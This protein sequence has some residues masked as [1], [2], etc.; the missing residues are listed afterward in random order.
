[1]QAFGQSREARELYEESL[2]LEP[3]N[4]DVLAGLGALLY[5]TDAP[6]AVELFQKAIRSRATLIRPYIL[7][8]HY[9]LVRQEFAR[10]FGYARQAMDFARVDRARAAL[11]EIMAI[12]ASELGASAD[13]VLPMISEA[14]RLAPNAA[15]IG[16]NLK[17]F[18]KSRDS[19]AAKAEW[20]YQEERADYAMKE[21]IERASLEVTA[22][23]G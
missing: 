1:M 16:E 14:A 11:L 10:A 8:A 19:H 6:R 3:E 7:L 9:H 21:P 22:F 13:E 2:R 4:P 17:A 20:V 5:D 18:M 12:S 15:R 23:A